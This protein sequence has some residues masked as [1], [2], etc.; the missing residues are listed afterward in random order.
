MTSQHPYAAAIG[1]PYVWVVDMDNATE[2]ERALTAILNQTVS[3]FEIWCQIY[4]FPKKA[5]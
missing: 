4:I 5:Q 2:V 3:T 1:E